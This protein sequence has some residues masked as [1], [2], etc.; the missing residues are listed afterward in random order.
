MGSLESGLRVGKGG[1]ILRDLG[2]GHGW[3]GVGVGGGGLGLRSIMTTNN[4][5]HLK[6]N[7]NMSK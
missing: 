5:C 1:N 4:F 3:V 7:Q 6:Q 2:G